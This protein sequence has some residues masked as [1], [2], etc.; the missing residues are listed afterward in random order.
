MANW[1]GTY[2]ETK[3][4]EIAKLIENGRTLDFNYDEES[5]TG[6]CSLQWG[7]NAIDMDAIDIIATKNGSSFFIRS[8]DNLTG[9]QHIWGYENGK[10]NIAEVN[11]FEVV[12]EDIEE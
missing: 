11:K 9:T 6:N 7:L 2:F 10:E 5:G 3:D 8:S 12:Y 1:Y 4:K